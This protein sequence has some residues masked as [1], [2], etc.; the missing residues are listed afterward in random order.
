MSLARVAACLLVL[1]AGG[2]GSPTG[3][4]DELPAQPQ[5]ISPAEGARATSDTP[6]LSVRNARGY[7]SGQA[8]Y[9]FRVFNAG[10]TRELVDPVT[11]PAGRTTTA[12]TLTTPLPRS[13][14]VTW[15]VTAKGLAGE[16]TSTRFTFRTVAVECSSGRDPYAKA[17]VEWFVPACSLA[18]NIYN[19]PLEVLGPPDAGGRA[20]DMFFGFMSLGY[21]GH[22]TVDM[23]GCAVDGPGPDVR[24]YQTASRE[25]VTLFAA[26]RPDGPFVLLEKEK[27]CGTPSD[28]LYSNH[29]DFDLATAELEEA[30]YFR[31]EDGELFPCPGDTVTE[32][33]DIDAI[34]ILHQKP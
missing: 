34:Q 26:G 31:I 19:D 18:Q 6:T 4:S 17:V 14:T 29:C 30:R 7:D 25:E 23:E 8:Q 21:Q 5:A 9:T 13:L 16:V 3:P 15:S 33:A 27:R 22:V 20:P 32:G 1:A 12:A 2:C 10:G 24:I 28:G 11:V